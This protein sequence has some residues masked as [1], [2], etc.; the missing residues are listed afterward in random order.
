MEQFG[1]R[2]FRKFSELIC[3]SFGITMG[4]A[5]KEILRTKLDRLVSRYELQS[6]DEYYKR[7]VERENKELFIEFANAIT[8]NMTSFFRENNHFEYIKN[9]MAGL[10]K[11]NPRIT[12][13]N[14]IRVWSSAC[15]TGEEPY[16]L[17]MVLKEHL[18][19]GIR[20][21]VLATDINSDVLA[22]AQKGLYPSSVKNDVGGEYLRRY[23][24]MYDGGYR[25]SGELRRLVTF[26]HFNLMDRFPFRD[27]FD[28]IFCRNVMI[29]FDT[30]V[31]QKLL[32]K[33]YDSLAP[34]GLLFIGH[35]ESISPHSHRFKYLQPTV[36]KKD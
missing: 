6:Y 26:R 5:K 21:K 20:I 36:Y 24:E 2:H 7:L 15:S 8:V 1:D 10:L 27:S 3:A 18:P 22:S 12:D 11:G 23:F 29:Y 35:S 9:N 16:T 30:V 31:R 13:R 19:G 28:M 17:S 14:E 25:I 32:D 34:G 33:L 4:E